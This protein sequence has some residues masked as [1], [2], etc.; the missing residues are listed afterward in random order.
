M[1][2]VISLPSTIP[3]YGKVP[4][5]LHSNSDQALYYVLLGS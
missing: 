4:Q 2:I 5:E 3:T 1:R